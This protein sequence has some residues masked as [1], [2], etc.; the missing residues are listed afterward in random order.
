MLTVKRRNLTTQQRAMA[1]ARAWSRA[2]AA[3]RV[4]TKGGDRRSKAQNARLITDPRKHFGA[5][6]GVGKD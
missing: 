5:L 3:G 6:Y 4:Q 2:W 1:A